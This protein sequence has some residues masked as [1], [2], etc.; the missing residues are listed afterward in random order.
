MGA[1]RLA[2]RSFAEEVAKAKQQIP[3][4]APNDK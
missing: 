2:G 3:R 4:T 1:T